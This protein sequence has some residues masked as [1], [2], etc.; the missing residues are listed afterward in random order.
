MLRGPTFAYREERTMQKHLIVVAG[1]SGD[2]SAMNS[3]LL[4][5]QVGEG[6]SFRAQT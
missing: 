4:R 6:G 5:M 2:A 1:P 3:R